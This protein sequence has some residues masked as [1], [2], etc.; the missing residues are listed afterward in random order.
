MSS[1]ARST[2]EVAGDDLANLVSRL[3]DQQT[4]ILVDP[5]KRPRYRATRVLEG[6]YLS[7]KRGA[8]QPPGQRWPAT[9]RDKGGIRTGEALQQALEDLV[10]GHGD[11]GCRLDACR[12]RR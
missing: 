10:R 9:C 2:H 11:S 3:L 7:E 1:G 4:S 12:T 5:D 8:S 6:D